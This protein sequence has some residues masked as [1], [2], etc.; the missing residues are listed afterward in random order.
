MSR[1]LPLALLFCVFSAK[2]LVAQSTP[3][4][5][6][7]AFPREALVEMET[8]RWISD[9]AVDRLQLRWE[10]PQRFSLWLPKLES[11][12][13][14]HQEPSEG[15]SYERWA[16]RLALLQ[17]AYYTA[18][19]LWPILHMRSFEQVTGPKTDDWLVKTVGGLI[20][21]LGGTLLTSALRDAPSR[22]LA[23]VAVGSAAALTAVDVIYVAQ[24]RISRI[25]LLDAAVESALIAGWIAALH[26]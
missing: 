26:K 3:A 18:T 15:E 8:G 20:A 1:N 13:A 10:R 7:L 25:Y 6:A 16:P 24:G 21:V 5:E 12:L 9:R 14:Q 22:D 2:A 4:P 19:G 11:A 17:G 23:T